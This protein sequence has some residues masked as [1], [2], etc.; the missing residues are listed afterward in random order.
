MIRRGSALLLAALVSSCSPDAG[1]SATGGAPLVDSLITAGEAAYADGDFGRA[2]E[3][4]GRALPLT[5][6]AGSDPAHEPRVLTHLSLAAY[7]RGELQERARAG[8]SRRRWR[9]PGSSDTSS[10]RASP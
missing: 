6:E 7:R 8:A 5:R 4:W 9:G 1:E 10:S 3:L 2:R